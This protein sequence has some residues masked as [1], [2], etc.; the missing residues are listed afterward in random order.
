[1]SQLNYPIFTDLQS[2]VLLFTGAYYY[3]QI[4]GSLLWTEVLLIS[5]FLYSIGFDFFLW[6]V[7]TLIVGLIEQIAVIGLRRQRFRKAVTNEALL[8]L[9]TQVKKDLG[10]GHDIELWCCDIDRSIFL[11]TVNPIF[12]AILFSESA[13]AIFLEKQ[14]RGKIVLAREVLAMERASP[15]RGMAIG[16]TIFI[17]SP[18]F[19]LFPEF[20]RLFFTIPSV[21][22]IDI[23]MFYIVIVALGTVLIMIVGPVVALR[24][25]HDFDHIIRTVYARSLQAARIEVLTGRKISDEAAEQEKQDKAREMLRCF[26]N[27]IRWSV[28]TS[29]IATVI[30]F[31]AV[32]LLLPSTIYLLDLAILLSTV[33]GFIIFLLIYLFAFMIQMRE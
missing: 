28:P 3:G 1:M 29:I 8:S 13:I 33:V 9:F 4:I 12:K 19:L 16:L 7:L 23:S 15:I 14:E 20:I 27:M 10:K 18:L 11:S 6:F 22:G 26:R 17:L 21:F 31:G 30:T 5:G 25:P 24:R 2:R 32:I